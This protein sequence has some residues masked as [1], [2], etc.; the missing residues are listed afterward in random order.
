MHPARVGSSLSA[1]STKYTTDLKT[2]KVS[3]LAD[4]ILSGYQDSNGEAVAGIPL[5]AGR[6]PSNKIV[7]IPATC[8]YSNRGMLTIFSNIALGECIA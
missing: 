6:M 7:F 5:S 1:T 3:E 4:L 2:K 8:I